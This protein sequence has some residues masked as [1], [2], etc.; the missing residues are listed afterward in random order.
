MKRKL[1]IQI[2]KPTPH[3]IFSCCFSIINFKLSDWLRDMNCNLF[4]K[5]A[6]SKHQLF[7]SNVTIFL[8]LMSLV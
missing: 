8:L 4:L 3:L 2:T 1:D 6:I 7:F 5:R